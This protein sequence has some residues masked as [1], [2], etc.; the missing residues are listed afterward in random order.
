MCFRPA[1]V[2]LDDDD[3]MFGAVA[4]PGAPG[5]PAAPDIVSK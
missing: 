4:A 2:T 5:A 1:A 3:D